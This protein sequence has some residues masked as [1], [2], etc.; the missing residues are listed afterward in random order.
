MK[1]LLSFIYTP[2]G[3]AGLVTAMQ[4]RLVS[5]FLVSTNLIIH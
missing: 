1:R 2:S 5:F 4:L 3:R